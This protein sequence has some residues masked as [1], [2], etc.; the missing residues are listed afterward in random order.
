MPTISQTGYDGIFSAAVDGVELSASPEA[1]ASKGEINAV[2]GVMLGTNEDE[3]KLLMPLTQPVPGAPLTTAEQFR[4]WLQEQFTPDVVEQVVKQ[5]TAADF[6]GSYWQAAEQVYTDSQYLCP[7]QRSASWLHK[8]GR[9]P[10][11]NV[12]VY[13][14][15]YKNP[16]SIVLGKIFYWWEWCRSIGPCRNDTKIPFGTPHG[17]EIPLVWAG[18]WALDPQGVALS[19]KMIHYWHSFASNFDPNG[20]QADVQWPAYINRSQ[21]VLLQPNIT[22]V[23]GLRKPFCDFWQRVLHLPMRQPIARHRV[24]VQI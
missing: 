2:K 10:S 21:T 20:N 23:A 15:T 14:F 11:G 13:E 17:T 1:L 8:S 3:G 5:Y 12:F 16:K 4:T 22:S 19:K 9:A 24:E 18:R 7:T 6:D